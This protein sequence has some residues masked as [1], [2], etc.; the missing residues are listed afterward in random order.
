MTK[1]AW[2]KFYAADYLSDPHLRLCSLEAQGLFT[3]LMC[4]AA[5]SSRKGYL[6]NGTMPILWQEF[7]KIESI[8]AR[9]CTS[10]ITELELYG[11]IAKDNMGVYYIPRMVRDAAQ[12]V[13]AQEHG[14]KGGNPELD[15][16][17]KGGVKGGVKLEADTDKDKEAEREGVGL[18]P[19]H[20]QRLE[21][22]AGCWNEMAEKCG[23]TKIRAWGKTRRAQAISRLA[24]NQWCLDCYEALK[25]IPRSDYLCGRKPHSSWRANIDWLLRPDTVTKIIEGKYSDP[26]Q[27]IEER[28]DQ[29]KDIDREVAEEVARLKR[30]EASGS[31]RG[32]VPSTIGDVLNPKKKEG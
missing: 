18:T 25:L 32:G 5:L 16:R 13:E 11:R 22:L 26:E 9:K 24:D 20:T 28:R 21:K 12:E 29:A 27:P 30:L 2:F 1:R 23:I 7:A 10:L 15:K 17:V 31:K 3:R 14:K 4:Y 6:F 8:R 19:T